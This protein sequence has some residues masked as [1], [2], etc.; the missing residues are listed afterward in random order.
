V[1][2]AAA[3]AAALAAAAREQRR[4]ELEDTVF[5]RLHNP[6]NPSSALC[7]AFVPVPYLLVKHNRHPQRGQA[8]AASV[9]V[10][11]SLWKAQWEKET[12]EFFNTWGNVGEGVGARARRCAAI[13]GSERARA[14][15]G[16]RRNRK[17]GKERHTARRCPLAAAATA[18]AAAAAAGR[19]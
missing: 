6:C 18:A 1:R 2:G 17:K 15:I 19:C 9:C 7:A 5:A 3:R 14:C 16:T 8:S 10:F 12:V 11:T 13:A 4:L